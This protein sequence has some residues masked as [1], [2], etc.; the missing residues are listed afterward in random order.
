MIIS[1]TSLTFLPEH[2]LKH[3]KHGWKLD[4]FEYRA[5]SDPKICVL[6]FVKEYTFNKE[7]AELIKI[8]R[9][10]LVRRKRYHMASIDTAKKK[11][12]VF[13]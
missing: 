4:V 3:S 11:K 1:S 7:T 9:G 10:Y 8:R 12:E 2:V 13:H 6:E 5:Y